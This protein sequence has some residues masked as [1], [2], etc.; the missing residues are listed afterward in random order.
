MSGQDQE[1]VETEVEA[2]QKQGKERAPA[3]GAQVLGRLAGAGM[4][5]PTMAVAYLVA[6]LAGVPGPTAVVRSLVSALVMWVFVA[7]M[8]RLLFGVLLEDWKKARSSRSR[9][10]VEG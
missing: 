3:S 8:V 10:E 1:E 6:V 4:A 2:P 5:L 9:R 7:L